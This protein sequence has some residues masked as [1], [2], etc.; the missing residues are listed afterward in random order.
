MLINHISRGESNM[1]KYKFTSVDSR[2]NQFISEIE[3]DNLYSALKRAESKLRDDAAHE[4]V[5]EITLTKVAES[6]AEWLEHL[7]R[8]N[9]EELA[10][11]EAR[12]SL[13]SLLNE[14]SFEALLESWKLLS[15][16]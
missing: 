9:G 16:E 2:G 13:D 4:W 6:H 11:R 14:M 3:A 5:V 10:R 15:E 1:A 7:A 8:K 12:A